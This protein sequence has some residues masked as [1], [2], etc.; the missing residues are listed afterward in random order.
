M[1]IVPAPTMSTLGWVID[2]VVKFDKLLSDFFL[3]DPNQSYLYA[4]SIVTMQSLIHQNP[5]NPAAF[6]GSLQESLRTYLEAYYTSVDVRASVE[7]PQADLARVTVML[8]IAV[9]D[10][11][12]SKQFSKML[13]TANGSLQKIIDINNGVA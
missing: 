8:N 5:T 11:G 10:N 12:A 3:A 1:S 9:N 7:N 2:P 13:L 4:K 6:V